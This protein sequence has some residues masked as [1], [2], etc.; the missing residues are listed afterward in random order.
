MT[1]EDSERAGV[2]LGVFPCAL[3]R[4]SASDTADRYDAAV[5]RAGIDFFLN[6]DGVGDADCMAIGEGMAV[7][8]VVE[9]VK[10][11]R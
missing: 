5:L 9:V 11:R 10:R 4:A 6:I 8:A 7:V 3:A 2:E 1:D